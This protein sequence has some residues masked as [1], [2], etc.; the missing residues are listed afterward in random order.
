MHTQDPAVLGN[1][2]DSMSDYVY[3]DTHTHTHTQKA[4]MFKM[5]KPRNHINSQLKK[6]VVYKLC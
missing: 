2:P 4:A 3:W 6:N 1:I 5:P